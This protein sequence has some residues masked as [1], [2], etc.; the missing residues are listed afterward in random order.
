M[1]VVL[2]RTLERLAPPSWVNLQR[3]VRL[4]RPQAWPTGLHPSLQQRRPA[5]QCP[6]LDLSLCHC[7]L[8]APPRCQ[9][10]VAEQGHAHASHDHMG[11]RM[12]LTHVLLTAGA[13]CAGNHLLSHHIHP[14][15]GPAREAS[16]FEDRTC[17]DSP[18][19]PRKN[20]SDASSGACCSVVSGTRAAS[21]SPQGLL[22]AG[23]PILSRSSIRLSSKLC[24]QSS[25]TQ[26]TRQYRV[27]KKMRKNWWTPAQ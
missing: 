10:S 21:P 8:P 5:R 24:G 3:A 9:G 26:V 1:A 16:S 13:G 27:F 6:P 2:T 11:A 18:A 17:P 20:A 4:V 12:G 19:A 25:I 14:Q 22:S 7:R 23:P 15:A